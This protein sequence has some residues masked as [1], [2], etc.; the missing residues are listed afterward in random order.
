MS[1]IESCTQESVSK[2]RKKV[3]GA[4]KIARMKKI[5]RRGKITRRVK[6]NGKA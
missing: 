5:A 3:A 6:G 1:E 4:R 2:G